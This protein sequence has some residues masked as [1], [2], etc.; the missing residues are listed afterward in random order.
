M[1][2]AVQRDAELKAKVFIS[3]SRKD[4][5]FADRLEAALKARGFEPLIDRTEIYALEDW[6]QRIQALIG[7]ADTIVFVLSPD[8]IISD[9]ALKEVAHGAALNK[10]FAPIVCRRVDD[11]V[12]PEP[13]RRLNF[14]FF[15]EPERFE[16]SADQLA[17][18]L[19]TD[20]GWIR[21]HTDFGEQARRWAIAGRPGPRGLLLRSPVLDEAE[22][23]I[24]ARPRG[25][26][27]PTEET[28]AFIAE[29]RRGAA[30][31]RNILTGSL[32]AG[33][34]VA[35]VLAGLAFWQRGIAIE[36][37]QLAVQQ[38]G[39]AVQQRQ[40]AEQQRDSALT[41]ESRFLV[42]L[43]NG[44]AHIE[45]RATSTLLALAAL[46]DSAAGVKRPL[47]AEAARVLFG[48]S[49]PLREAAV[50]AGHES[51]VDSGG[52]FSPDGSRILTVS[53]DSAILRDAR[54][55]A[56]IAKLEGQTGKISFATFS[57]DSSRIV[58]RSVDS[59]DLWEDSAQLWDGKT[60]ALIA[61]LK[62][63]PGG[64]YVAAFSPDDNRVITASMEDSTARLWD[65]KTGA[66]IATLTGRG[67]GVNI[68]VF[69]SD[70]RRVVTTPWG[71]TIPQLWDG[72]TG[73]LIATLEG[74]SGEISDAA[75]SPDDRRIVT[76]AFED[77]AARLWDAETG[78]LIATLDGHGGS[79]S[80]AAFSPDGGRVITVGASG[81]WL[82]HGHTGAAIATLKPYSAS[83]A[84]VGDEDTVY[85][86]SDG[87]RIVRAETAQL[88]D[89]KTGALIA[90][91]EGNTP[92]F[93]PDGSRIV[94]TME[95]DNTA[96]LWDGKTGGA[97]A[98]L[99][100]HG[101]KVFVEGFSR[102]GRRLLT[103]A[104]GTADVWD[105]R[106]GAGIATLAGHLDEVTFAAF[107]PDGSRVATG[108]RD[109]TVRLWDLTRPPVLQSETS[110]AAFS[111]DRSL[112]VVTAQNDNTAQVWDAKTGAV[113]AILKGHKGEVSSM[114][115]SPDGSRIVTGSADGTAR[116]WDAHT[117]AAIVT[118]KGHDER[119]SQAV[120]SSDGKRI[121]TASWDKTARVW[122]AQTGAAI[123]VLSGHGEMLQDAAFSPD[124]TRVVTA[125]GRLNLSDKAKW[126]SKDNSARVWDARTGALII[127]LK[128]FAEE[129]EKA[130]YSPDGKR[131]LTVSYENAARLWDAA[132]G[133]LI[134]P[135]E[136]HQD[137][138]YGAAFSADGSRIVTVSKDKTARVWDGKTGAP[139]RILSG[140][141]DTVLSAAFSPDGKRIVTASS[142]ETA[143]VWDVQTG[144]LL[145]TLS[146]HSGVVLAAAF[147]SKS[148][149]VITAS[150][151]DPARIWRLFATNQEL[152]DYAKRVVPRCLTR[153]QR[154]RAY[155]GPEPPD[156]C[157]EMQKWPNRTAA[158]KE[159]LA[160]KKAGKKLPLPA[161]E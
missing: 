145:E 63:H 11:A 80:H 13:L 77:K 68:A 148:N 70:S 40:I 98:T 152:V 74:H 50:L 105:A 20:I 136:G 10:R 28:Q 146:G 106:T 61:M 19:T 75:F 156:W 8:A 125:S 140:H 92:R 2:D 102:D 23:W 150:A 60:G 45:D 137:V 144:E 30:R 82:W 46:P 27:E 114:A 155:L 79:V 14:I 44:A 135:L 21:Q 76:A 86:S 18:A 41:A 55:G 95:D 131:I 126:D 94:T 142:D 56:T 31:R 132:T 69:S 57:S 29:S 34:V 15:D 12:V 111:V 53:A 122:D 93:N 159:W 48:A 113:T 153:Q 81:A 160:E 3:Y 83:E 65:G 54:S 17:E 124:G 91:L 115:F 157:I 128:G 33:L 32:G 67:R 116:V 66:S 120:F 43:A 85:F 133:I 90:S 130:A 88:Y 36:Q 158:W 127:T 104:S 138:V 96:R 161:E 87:S 139:I 117:G 103:I 59:A 42:D 107:S 71:D 100:G 84:S 39:I 1:A 101:G 47:V 123:A 38:R 16:T 109:K 7:H 5:A 4:M 147:S 9:V 112:V 26:P 52:M 72:K 58:T 129:V 110:S 37:R 97:V 118:L 51:A 35:V 62:G 99:S 73:A 143:R 119:V 6:W 121:V 64:V 134:A 151:D 108:S 149:A 141:G 89:G 78:A 24:A 22:R 154:E 25:A 49:Q